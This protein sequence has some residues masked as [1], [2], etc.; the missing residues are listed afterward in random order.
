MVIQSAYIT[1]S[2]EEFRHLSQTY[3][4]IPVYC[5]FMADLETPVS[6]YLKIKRG[7]YSYLLESVEGGKNISRYSFIGTEPSEVI[8]FSYSTNSGN[9]ETDILEQL[10]TRFSNIK[11]AKL[12]G[13]P[14]FIGGAIGYLSYEMVHRF[15]PTVP[16]SL[17]DGMGE[18][19]PDAMFML[20]DTLVI[21]DHLKHEMNILAHVNTSKGGSLHSLYEQAKQKITEIANRLKTPLR[22]QSEILAMGNTTR[23]PSKHQILGEYYQNVRLGSPLPQHP[24][25]AYL[26]N[27]TK[28]EFCDIVNKCIENITNGELIQVVISQRLL[29]KTCAHPFDIYRSL[30]NVNPSPY[31]FFLDMG[32]FQIVGASPERLVSVQNGEITV[33]PI[34]GTKPRGKS[35]E[36]DLEQ[37]RML[38]NSEKEKA[39][40]VMLLDLGRNDVG[41]VAIPGTVHVTRNMEVEHYSHVMH[42]VSHVR[43]RLTK[44]TD[45]FDA[46]RACFPAGTISGAPKVRAMQLISQLEPNK[47]GVYS[48]T[49]GYI[50]Y[51]GDMDSCIAIRTMLTQNGIAYLQAGAGIVYDS[52]P[53]VEYQETIDKMSSLMN[54]IENA[55]TAKSCLN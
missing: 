20:T 24:K 45:S 22:R 32:N 2:F 36:E 17:T 13:L 55:E 39:E 7:A 4:L 3:N 1:P 26:A 48:G 33:H 25:G 53:E 44:C 35:V 30:R 16:Q 29:R 31:M 27:I 46:M 34:A 5:R 23:N 40:H 10:K 8:K 11:P 41:R 37:E 52:Q 38:M 9:A 15:E 42:I 21:F 49:V 43:G 28:N 19:V 50:S 18:N 12:S 47:R 54:A 14:S 51:S 6:S